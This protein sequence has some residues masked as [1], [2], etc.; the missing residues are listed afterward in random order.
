VAHVKQ[1]AKGS[2]RI[3]RNQW[4]PERELEAF[5]AAHPTWKR[6]QPATGRLAKKAFSFTML[7][8]PANRQSQV[9]E[10]MPTVVDRSVF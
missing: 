5:G 9:E 10:R 7:L 2:Q 4:R 8:V 3:H 6:K 1:S